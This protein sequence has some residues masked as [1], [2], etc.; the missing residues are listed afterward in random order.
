MTAPT[1]GTE[2]DRYL[3]RVRAALADLPDD[4]RNELIEDLSAHLADIST[5]TQDTLTEASLV[6]RLGRP[7]AYAAELRASAGL[8]PAPTAARAVA[9]SRL[10]LASDRVRRT[11]DAVPAYHRFRGF[12]PELRP[13]WW[14][15]R[16]YF[17]TVVVAAAL[18]TDFDGVLPDDSGATV[19]FLVCAGLVAYASVWLGRRSDGYGRWG[20]RAILAGGIF[21]TLVAIGVIGS[22]SN[23]DYYD[24]ASYSSTGIE[25]AT[26][27][28]VYGPDGQLIKD[29]QVFDQNG[30]PVVLS[31]DCSTS[32]R[33]RTDGGA[34]D[35]V[36]P[37]S[38]SQ[39]V[40]E[41]CQVFDEPPVPERLPGLLP[42]DAA[43][44]PG[45]PGP[46]TSAT[47]TTG[48]TPSSGAT[49]SLGATA[50]TTP[51]GSAAPTAAAPSVAPTS[52]S[53]SR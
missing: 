23:S 28:R 32:S 15:L 47:P 42:T 40:D 11:L 16:A 46:T 44:T 25:N 50:S 37:K 18:G 12:L 7:E 41:Y 5:E 24:Y 14:L 2:A 45:V 36:Y 29:A 8:A 17:L 13:G 33:V 1:V 48:A 43:P 21:V 6:E 34:A 4:E 27:L 19:A 49:P 38:L 51:G 10:R 52:P 3:Q 53:P 35:N 30:N 26:D 39:P 31:G 9:V 22:S 20:R